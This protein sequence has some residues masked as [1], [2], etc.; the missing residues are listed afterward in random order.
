MYGISIS[1]ADTVSL[2]CCRVGTFASAAF[3][4]NIG[5][6]DII[7]QKQVIEIMVV[8]VVLEFREDANKAENIRK[9]KDMIDSLEGLIP[10]LLSMKTGINFSREERA[11]DLCLRAEFE[12]RKGLREYAEHPEHLK[13][14]EFLKTVSEYSKV[15]DYETV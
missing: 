4:H 12:D 8:H 15:V 9:A 2:K 5:K 6:L 7:I 10:S 11:M 13:V 1:R 14:I 3:Y